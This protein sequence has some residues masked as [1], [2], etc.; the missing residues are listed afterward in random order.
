[1]EH[2]LPVAEVG[3]P[4]ALAPPLLLGIYRSPIVLLTNSG[5]SSIQA[6]SYQ[7]PIMCLRLTR[8]LCLSDP[9]AIW[10]AAFR[11]SPSRHQSPLLTTVVPSTNLR[12]TS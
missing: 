5:R 8:A 12:F 10:L 6:N 7:V 9:V 3:L 1:M 2:Q 11:L 4:I